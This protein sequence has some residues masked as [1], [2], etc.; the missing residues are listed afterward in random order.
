[1]TGIQEKLILSESKLR[2]DCWPPGG[3][4][5][6]TAVASQVVDLVQFELPTV[7][8]CHYDYHHLQEEETLSS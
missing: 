3:R 5:Q 8:K 2:K 1:M 7:H 4:G 6:C